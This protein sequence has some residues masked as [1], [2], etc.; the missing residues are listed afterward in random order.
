M[1]IRVKF[2]KNPY[3]NNFTCA[4]CRCS[5]DA[6]GFYMSWNTAATWSISDL[7]AVF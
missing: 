6:N 7:F 4:L 5:F 3:G 1:K 2:G